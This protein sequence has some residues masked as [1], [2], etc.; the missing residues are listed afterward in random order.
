VQLLASRK[1]AAW[2][3]LFV[4]AFAS[5]FLWGADMKPEEVIAKHLDAIGTAEARKS[6]K[7]R[8][9]QGSA[10]YRIHSGGSGA[11]DGK[12][13]IA[14]EGGKSNFLFKINTN[15]YRGEQFICDGNKTSVAG[16]YAD[17][18]RSEFGDFVLAQNV[19]LREPLLAGVWTSGW[20]LLDIEAHKA[21]VHSEGTKKVDG[22]N[23]IALRYRPKKGTDLDIMLYFDPQTYQHV[24]TAY[25]ASQQTGLGEGEIATARKQP[26]RYEIE[27]RFSD[28]QTVDG[29]TLPSHYDLRFTE[30]QESGFT[31]SVEWEVRATNISNNLTIDPRSFEVK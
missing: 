24:M 27:E 1:Q 31:K 19:V 23:L 5:T 2:I 22:R 21:Q 29:L 16:T 6:V 3:L 7:S 14:S 18:T 26:T 13:V 9:V 4:L 11:I 17:K 30:E 20:P 12:S 8:V 25:K 28:F 10:T 15:G